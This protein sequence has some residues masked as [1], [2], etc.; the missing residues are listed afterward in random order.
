[1]ARLFLRL[2]GLCLLAVA[3]VVPGCQALFPGDAT[4]VSRP[5]LIRNGQRP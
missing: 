5:D 2:L 4:E 1:M 3:I